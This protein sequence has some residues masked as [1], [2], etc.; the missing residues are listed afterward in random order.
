MTDQEQPGRRTGVSYPRVLFRSLA[1]MVVAALY[2]LLS[3]MAIVVVQARST[4]LAFRVSGAP[5]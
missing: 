1:A 5:C 2:V 3:L 4:I